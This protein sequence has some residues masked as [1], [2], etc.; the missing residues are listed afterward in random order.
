MD[1]TLDELNNNFS[2]NKDNGFL[3]W[4]I[5]KRAGKRAGTLDFEGYR[6]T[7]LNYRKMREHR[8][9]FLI[10]KGFLPPINSEID[11]ING[12]IDDN[13]IENLRIANSSDNKCNQRQRPNKA[14]Y[15]GVTLRKGNF[16]S[17]IKKNGKKHY[18]GSYKTALEA[19]LVYCAAA[20]KI[21]GE[22]ANF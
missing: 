3:I 8:A 13:R 9:I 11:H 14:G 22:F 4:K 1:F 2:Y 17:Y 16:V 6:V 18:L 12:K 7:N 20:K 10:E 19:H 15:K 5:G 21:H